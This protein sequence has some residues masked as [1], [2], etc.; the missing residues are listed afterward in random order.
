MTYR[1]GF[2]L[3]LTLLEDVNEDWDLKIESIMSKWKMLWFNCFWKKISH[4]QISRGSLQT[5]LYRVLTIMICFLVNFTKTKW[6][7]VNGLCKHSIIH[8]FAA[9]LTE[10][11]FS[12][13]LFLQ[14]D[15][16]FNSWEKIAELS[17]IKTQ[18]MIPQQ[19]QCLSWVTIMEKRKDKTMG[20]TNLVTNT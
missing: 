16:P 9:I 8:V 10:T 17:F 15:S 5:W 14:K 13:H 2:R 20:Y 18:P 7:N 19:C 4:F 3:D 6:E 12:W 11:L 1:W